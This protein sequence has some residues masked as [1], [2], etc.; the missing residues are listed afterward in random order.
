MLHIH[1]LTLEQMFDLFCC[2]FYYAETSTFFQQGISKYI[3]HPS[4]F[5]KCWNCMHYCMLQWEKSLWTH[6][7]RKENV[8][9]CI[10]IYKEIPLLHNFYST[11]CI[12]NDFPFY[13]V[14]GTQF[15]CTAIFL[16]LLHT[17]DP[18]LFPIMVLFYHT[19][20]EQ[21]Y[22]AKYNIDDKEEVAK[23]FING[24]MTSY[25]YC[26]FHKHQLY[27]HWISKC[28]EEDHFVEELCCGTN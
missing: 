26:S 24:L 23:E 11:N 16:L 7:V 3:P 19:N 13:V 9:C 8:S 17:F 15:Y 28:S 2:C 1:L 5:T 25:E 27:C 20:T 12:L 18:I 21:S 6:F 14:P 10:V 22:N 4:T